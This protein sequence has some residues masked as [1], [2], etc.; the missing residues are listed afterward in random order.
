MDWRLQSPEMLPTIRVH[1]WHRHY[2]RT[3]GIETHLL[4]KLLL[5]LPL[6]PHPLLGLP[7]PP[8]PVATAAG[9]RGSEG[10]RHEPGNENGASAGVRARGWA[11][12]QDLAPP[13]LLEH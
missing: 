10:G 6:H 13:R 7:V 12:P 11:V 9:A 2:G 5:D 3:T 4:D 8:R 1:D